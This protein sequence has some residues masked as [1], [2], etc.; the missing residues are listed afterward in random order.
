MANKILLIIGVFIILSCQNKECNF[1]N[2]FLLKNSATMPDLVITSSKNSCNELLVNGNFRYNLKIYKIVRDLALQDSTFKYMNYKEDIFLLDFTT[3]KRSGKL[4][5]NDSIILN[6]NFYMDIYSNNQKY[7]LFKIEDIGK[8]YTLNLSKI[9]IANY[10][11]GIVGELTIG[12]E[13][14][15]WY[16]FDNK[17]YIPNKEYI[18]S[19][20][21]NAK[22]Q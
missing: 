15:H 4:I 11:F 1:D 17:G 19:I 3:K 5:L 8:Y 18:Y 9:Y 10:C 7:R 22:L 2:S 21:Q 14:N 20:F 6:T 16:V 13:N 12:K